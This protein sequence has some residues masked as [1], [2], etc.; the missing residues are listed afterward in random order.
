MSE[1]GAER[2]LFV[3][4]TLLFGEVLEVVVGRDIRG[5]PATLRGFA[6]YAI[7]GREYPAVV[8]E[9]GASVE[10]AVLAGLSAAE[11]ALLDEYEDDDYERIAVHVAVEGNTAACVDADVYAFPERTDELVGRWS[12]ESFREEHLAAFVGRLRAYYDGGGIS[13]DDQ[14]GGPS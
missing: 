9:D 4:G 3:Y 6:R 1:A 10:G 12:P 7:R 14:D 11:R 2:P 8:R 5:T 13:S